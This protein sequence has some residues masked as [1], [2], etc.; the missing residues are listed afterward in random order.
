MASSPLPK[1]RRD[2]TLLAVSVGVASAALIAGCSSDSDT[3]GGTTDAVSDGVN[4]DGPVGNLAQPDSGPDTIFNPDG[5]V[6]NTALPADT[7]IADTDAGSDATTTDAS[8][9]TSD[10]D[11]G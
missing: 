9:G 1:K 3:G 4:T 7:G 2:R 5:P 11:G 10:A 8:D 6:G